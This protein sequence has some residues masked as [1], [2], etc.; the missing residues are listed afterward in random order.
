M[1]GPAPY[2]ASPRRFRHYCVLIAS[3]DLCARALTRDIIGGRQT[4]Y[5]SRQHQLLCARAINL[6]LLP[7]PSPSTATSSC[8][9]S[10]HPRL[11]FTRPRC[12]YRIGC[13][14]RPVSGK[15]L[16]LHTPARAPEAPGEIAA[17]SL[18]PARLDAGKALRRRNCPLSAPPCL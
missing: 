17:A 5:P 13:Y 6:P 16:H 8:L 11:S 4:P 15:S 14:P 12:E 10:P 9:P 18:Q 1:S 2:H 3:A 7:L